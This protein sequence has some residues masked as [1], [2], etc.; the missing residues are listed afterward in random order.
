MV[1]EGRY[2]NL[3]I[4]PL[5][6]GDLDLWKQEPLP[7][8]TRTLT[9]TRVLQ[10]KE[11]TKEVNMVQW[12]GATL[13]KGHTITLRHSRPGEGGVAGEDAMKT[14][15]GSFFQVIKDPSL[16]PHI[17]AMAQIYLGDPFAKQA[18]DASMV[19]LAY[20]DQTPWFPII[21]PEA[22]LTRWKE[23]CEKAAP[24]TEA[25]LLR[26]Y[27]MGAMRAALDEGDAMACL[28]SGAD[29]LAAVYMKMKARWPAIVTPE[30]ENF[31][32]AHSR[33]EGAAWLHAR[34]GD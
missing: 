29:Q 33:G 34:A 1:N 7:F 9:A 27:M 17:K 18:A 10:T 25:H 15:V 23:H 6:G 4:G 3:Q 24:G 13:Y 22:V 12:I 2:K 31:A 32:A 26:A 5:D 21:I 20:L 19:V 14:F 8:A 30:M 16:R 11:G 28:K